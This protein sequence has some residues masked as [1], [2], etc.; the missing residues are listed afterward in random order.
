MTNHHPLHEQ[1]VRI[2]QY[3]GESLPIVVDASVSAGQIFGSN[4]TDPD[5]TAILYAFDRMRT[6]SPSPTPGISVPNIPGPSA[7]SATQY[8][9][10]VPITRS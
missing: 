2:V 5:Q 9:A 3:S 7:P 4:F 1:L 6:D 10:E 8:I